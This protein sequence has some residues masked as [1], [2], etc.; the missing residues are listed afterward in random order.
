MSKTNELEEIQ[1]T[2]QEIFLSNLEYFKRDYSLLYRKVVNF[3]ESGIQN[4]SLEFT[5]NQFQLIHLK[6]KTNLYHKNPFDDSINRINNFE[7]SSAFS[8]IKMEEFPK[9]NH[10]KN[11]INAYKFVNEYINKFDLNSLDINKFIFI[12][13]L[14]GVHINDF[15]KAMDCK[16]YLIIEPNIEIFRLSMFLTD[17]KILS[18]KVKLF[19]AINDSKQEFKSTVQKFLNEDFQFNN[20]IHFEKAD[21]SYDY[22]I[23]DLTIIFNQNSQMRYPFSEYLLSMKRGYNHFLNSEN[24]ILNISKNLEILKNEKVLFLGAGPSLGKKI[25]WLYLNQEKFVIIA[26][27]AVLKYLQ[28]LEIVPDIILVIDGQKKQIL[29]QFDVNE[30][31]Y[32]NSIILS[33]FKIDDNVYKKIESNYTFY[34]QNSI[35]IF[36]GYGSLSGITVGDIG[37]DL[38]LRFGAEELY[39]LGIDA[40][41]DSIS[42]KTH[43]GTHLSSRK[44]NLKNKKNES[45]N[46]EESIIYV[47]GNL[48]KE[49]PTFYEYNEMIEEINLRLLNLKKDIKIYNLGSGAFFENT[50]PKDCKKLKVISENIE[51]NELKIKIKKIFKALCKKSFNINDK[52]RINNEKKILTILNELQGDTFF[53]EVFKFKKEFPSSLVLNIFVNYYKLI[54]PYLFFIKNKSIANQILKIQTNNILK[55]FNALLDKI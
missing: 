52:N 55:E 40:S 26:S 48:E 39:L 18:Q 30:Y 22:F 36:Q 46:F 37:I 34:I 21:E 9:R 2:L 12:G 43:I 4:Y 10:Y 1:Q 42:G 31:M 11:E 14:L 23:D 51:K 29:D 38:I 47:K 13:T 54:S 5:E 16:S 17:Y 35:E 19:F 20:F 53:N 44:V 41:I 15:H 33:T 6:N 25:E 24:K 50:I 28:I 7:L 49:V 27:S 8:L 45:T 3:E 32:K